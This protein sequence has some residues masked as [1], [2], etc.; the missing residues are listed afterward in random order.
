MVGSASLTSDILQDLLKCIQDFDDTDVLPKS[1][2]DGVDEE[3]GQ[4]IA[5]FCR[6]EY[7]QCQISMDCFLGIET[8]SIRQQLDECAAEFCTFTSVPTASPTLRPTAAGGDGAVGLIMEA[9]GKQFKMDYEHITAGNLGT[10]PSDTPLEGNVLVAVSCD[11]SNDGDTDLDG[12]FVIIK[13]GLCNVHAAA[14]I[15]FAGGAKVLVFAGETSARSVYLPRDQTLDL[16]VL[17]VKFED[18]NAIQTMMRRGK[19][20][21]GRLL[22]APYCDTMHAAGLDLAS[23]SSLLSSSSPLSSS[24]SSCCAASDT[25]LSFL[26]YNHDFWNLGVRE[27]PFCTSPP[28]GGADH[29]CVEPRDVFSEDKP[30]VCGY[31][32]KPNGVCEDGGEGSLGHACGWGGDCGDCGRRDR[33]TL[34]TTATEGTYS[35]VA[36]GMPTASEYNDAV[37]LLCSDSGGGR[38]QDALLEK[39]ADFHGQDS[40]YFSILDTLCLESKCSLA[41]GLLHYGVPSQAGADSCFAAQVLGAYLLDTFFSVEDLSPFSG[42]CTTKLDVRSTFDFVCAEN[43]RLALDAESFGI[44]KSTLCAAAESVN[45]ATD[46]LTDLRREVRGHD[47]A[48]FFPLEHM[49]SE[50]DG[51]VDVIC[52]TTGCHTAYNVEMELCDILPFAEYLTVATNDAAMSCCEASAAI[53][54]EVA[55]RAD[56]ATFKHNHCSTGC[57][58][59]VQLAE[60]RLA[61][62]KVVLRTSPT[63]FDTTWAVVEEVRQG[64]QRGGAPGHFDAAQFQNFVESD[65]I[66][67]LRWNL[68]SVNVELPGDGCKAADVVLAQHMW[69]YYPAIA[70]DIYAAAA[71]DPMDDANVARALS[72]I[73]DYGWGHVLDSTLASHAKDLLDNFSFE[74]LCSDPCRCKSDIE[75]AVGCGFHGLDEETFSR[76]FCYVSE[77][78]SCSTAVASSEIFGESWAFCSV[79]YDTCQAYDGTA[80]PCVPFVPEGVSIF[81][82]AGETI[83]SLQFIRD[84]DDAA[85]KA[86]G[87]LGG[88]NLLHAWLLEAALVS[89]SC[90]VAHGQLACDT[91][92]RRCGDVGGIAV[93]ESVCHSDCVKLSDKLARCSDDEVFNDLLRDFDG[94]VVCASQ[95]LPSGLAAGKD[96]AAGAR[97]QGVLGI[98]TLLDT[99][100]V[101]GN[102]EA[103]GQ[104]VYPTLNSDPSCFTSD[105]NDEKADMEKALVQVSCPDRFVKNAA[106]VGGGAEAQFCVGHCPS[107]AYTEHE[108]WGLWLLYTVPG[109]TALVFNGGALFCFLSGKVNKKNIEGSTLLL[110]Q[111]GTMAG[112]LGV[113][114]LAVLQKDLL[115]TCENELCLRT[116]VVCGLNQLSVY[117]LMGIC[118]C[119]VVKFNHLLKTMKSMGRAVERSK[120][121]H[122]L[123]WVVPLVFATASFVLQEEGNERFHLARSGVK[124]QFRYQ[125]LQDEALLLH[126]PLSVCVLVMTLSVIRVM[127]LCGQVMILSH[128]SFSLA[129]LA[130]VI[131]SRPEMQKMVSVSCFSTL[132]MV[133]WMLQTVTSHATFGNYFESMDAWLRCIRF[134]FARHAA[135]GCEWV[136]VVREYSDGTECPASPAGAGLFLSQ[137]LKATFEAL[138]PFMVASTFSWK[139]IREARAGSAKNSRRLKKKQ[140]V[141]KVAPSEIIHS[142]S[143]DERP[144]STNM[145]DM[146]GV[147]GVSGVQTDSRYASFNPAEKNMPPT[148]PIL[149]QLCKHG[150][151]NRVV[152]G[153]VAEMPDL[154]QPLDLSEMRAPELLPAKPAPLIKR[155]SAIRRQVESDH[156]AITEI[157]QNDAKLAD[158]ALQQKLAKRKLHSKKNKNSQREAGS[159][160]EVDSTTS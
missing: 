107:V 95:L 114:P 39:Y 22:S 133:I 128:G 65:N 83:D 138:M 68:P 90:Y 15:A 99:D 59:A 7:L 116:D 74:S 21:R 10:I 92:L 5:Q 29:H 145:S 100:F 70:P 129:N 26:L 53:V 131:R 38:C 85:A 130:K 159:Q 96:V 28:G 144:I 125:S 27:Y 25:V 47:V 54:M 158:Q 69:H 124:C 41:G 30:D 123:S 48:L 76:P 109:L 40:L 60:T 81:V 6:T 16:P 140:S 118:F 52:D 80:G 134:D 101:A 150:S 66:C 9:G 11:P 23:V 24:P 115:C 2:L 132:L 49:C 141:K 102:I 120:W 160:R 36:Y 56:P 135:V 67:L 63:C 117:V 94:D 78:E 110:I 19:D 139:I 151:S 147:S 71:R 103:F 32:C 104:S 89:P 148:D 137:V 17:S 91:R 3:R 77:P 75:S 88:G 84:T 155:E 33:N 37:A 106:V 121:V 12:M 97:L 4:C 154:P 82:P 143:G 112:I 50:E 43:E 18:A 146:S 55:S 72:S 57:T 136:D 44:A 62:A 46:M 86:L 113:V 156:A 98:D 157:V 127:A 34:V 51:A 14:R 35:P 1:Y 42:L 119:L 45:M 58:E 108:Y 149:A 152:S 122:H 142:F 73:C 20:V 126:L 8:N 79:A 111:L 87:L 93:P 105:L 64:L 61:E 13:L 31:L 153:R